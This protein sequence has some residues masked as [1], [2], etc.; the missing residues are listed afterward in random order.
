MPTPIVL[1]AYSK[2]VLS[3]IVRLGLFC[4]TLWGLYLYVTGAWLAA[5]VVVVPP[6]IHFWWL[7]ARAYRETVADGSDFG[8]NGPGRSNQNGN[9]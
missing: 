8:E 3:G 4:L 2:Q 7:V 6:T 9:P 1:F 5:L